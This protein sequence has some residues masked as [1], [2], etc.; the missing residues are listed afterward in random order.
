MPNVNAVDYV[1]RHKFSFYRFS[2][3][4][5]YQVSVTVVIQAEKFGSDKMGFPRRLA[6]ENLYTWKH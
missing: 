4:G 2:A 6:E 5:S 1:K 3:I